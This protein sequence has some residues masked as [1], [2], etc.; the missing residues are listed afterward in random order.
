MTRS[1]AA[2]TASSRPRGEES[3]RRGDWTKK[4]C[5]IGTEGRGTR[6]RKVRG[7]RSFI[8][9]HKRTISRAISQI[10]K[11]TAIA[12]FENS[13]GPSPLLFLTPFRAYLSSHVSLLRDFLPAMVGAGAK[14]DADAASSGRR[15]CRDRVYKRDESEKRITL[16]GTPPPPP[17]N[18]ARHRAE[19]FN[20]R[21]GQSN[22]TVEGD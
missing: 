21:V 11:P 6:G 20:L 7:G 18:F 13:P 5:R 2:L 16:K 10:G 3:P 12:R 14:S 19:T 1:L 4:R 15:H 22:V 17:T 9:A 8:S